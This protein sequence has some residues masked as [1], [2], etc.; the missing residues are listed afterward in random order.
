M[1]T[2]EEKLNVRRLLRTGNELN[3]KIATTILIVNDS[4]SKN[5]YEIL[6]E[7]RKLQQ[8]NRIKFNSLQKDLAVCCFLKLGDK[9]RWRLNEKNRQNQYLANKFSGA[10]E[11]AYAHGP[12]ELAFCWSIQELVN[13]EQPLETAL[14]DTRIIIDNLK[15]NTGTMPDFEERAARLKNI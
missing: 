6:Q 13:R 1:L 7:N 14:T 15:H 3:A 9:C 5:F 4:D 12:E 2:H 10:V 11:L 8:A